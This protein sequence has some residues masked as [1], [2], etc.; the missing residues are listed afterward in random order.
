MSD[1]VEQL[2]DHFN[3][4]FSDFRKEQRERDGKIFDKIDALVEHD[5]E[6][7][8]AIQRNE[9]KI[10][11]VDKKADEIAGDLDDTRKYWSRKFHFRWSTLYKVLGWVFGPSG[12][13]ALAWFI[14]RTLSAEGPSNG[15]G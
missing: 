12:L 15:I 5:H 14:W 2:R 4:T 10:E 7:D 11:N 3:E 13:I 6:Q 8:L 1:Q 9:N